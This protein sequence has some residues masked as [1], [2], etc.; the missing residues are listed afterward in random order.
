MVYVDNDPIVLAHARAL[1]TS[2]P[3]GATAYIDADLREPGKILGHPDLRGAL[4][5]SQPVGLMLVAILMFFR[6]T[7]GL[8]GMVARLLAALP[9]GS[10]LALTHPTADFNPE[11]MQGAV[12]C[13][14]Q[15]FRRRS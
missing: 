9:S 5:L 1:L 3:E 7:E 10:Y 8:Q 6:D 12:A 15:K 11:A 4:D 13:G 2:S 14:C